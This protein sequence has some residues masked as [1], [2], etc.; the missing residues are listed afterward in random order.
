MDEQKDNSPKRASPPDD[1]NRVTLK[2]FWA[3]C[4]AQ[5][6]VAIPQMLIT[7][8]CLLGAYGIVYLIFLR[9]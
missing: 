3:L 7:L 6:R 2:E 9:N 4:L 1:A 8:G 5:Y